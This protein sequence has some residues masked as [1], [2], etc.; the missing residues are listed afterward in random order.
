MK[1]KVQ[2]EPNTSI[3]VKISRTIAF[4]FVIAVSIYVVTL[5]QA[6]ADKLE[7]FGYP[8]IFFLS[9]LANATVF[10]PAPGLLI[11]FSMGARF[12]PLG[13]A[14]AAGLGATIGEMSGYLAGFSGQAIIERQ[15][16]YK[17]MV[18]WMERNG[19][20]T[21]TVLAFIPNPFFDLTGIAAGALKMPVWK[22]MLYAFVGKFFKMLMVS[23]AGA[24][25]YPL[26]WLNNILS[27]N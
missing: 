11:V 19:P 9:V 18:A 7:G 14:L 13:V 27:P 5:P 22:F 23:A 2:A 6:Q 10:L 8:G 24:G 3:W 26:P 25:L 15:D 4:I 20:A 21:V 12:P 16:V 17:K 1:S